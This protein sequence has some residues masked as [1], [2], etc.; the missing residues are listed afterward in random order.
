MANP[1]PSRART[2]LHAWHVAHGAHFADRD[3]WLLPWAYPGEEAAP[4]VRLGL[5]LVDVSA[6]V[7]VAVLGRDVAGF[8]RTLAGDGAVSHPRGVS[9]ITVTGPALAC[10]LTDDHLLILTEATDP[11]AVERCLAPPRQAHAVVQTD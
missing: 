9:A 7:K 2:P 5:G 3:G 1:L 11:A 8:A 10:R 4:P 6:L